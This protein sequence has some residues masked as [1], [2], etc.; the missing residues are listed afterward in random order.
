MLFTVGLIARYE[1][2]LDRGAAVKL[3][4]AEGYEGGWVWATAEAAQAFLVAERS[5]SIRRVYGVLADWEKDTQ[6]V[7]GKPY[8]V[9]LRNAEVV[10]LAAPEA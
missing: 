8:R 4:R 10:R 1:P 9:L 3:G 2:Q 5:V 7:E 6:A